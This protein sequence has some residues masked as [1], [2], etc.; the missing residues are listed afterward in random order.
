MGRILVADDS[1]LGRRVALKELISKDKGLQRR[2]AREVRITARL[3]HPGIVPVYEAGHWPD[4]EPFYAMKLVS[5]TSLEK[6]V[7]T[8]PELEERL[9][10]LPN[11]VHLAEAIAYAHANGVIHR[12]LKP[13]NVLVGEYGET[14]VVDWGLAKE[15]GDPDEV[16][17]VS[18]PPAQMGMTVHGAIVGTPAYMPPEQARGEAVGARAD[19]YSLGALIWHVLVGRPPYLGKV[20]EILTAVR[21]RPPPSLRDAA[22]DVPEELASIVEH[23]MERDPD[24]R[25][26]SARELAEELSRFQ[27]GQLV[28]RH[29]YSTWELVKRW[30]KRHRAAVMSSAALLVGAS[31]VGVIAMRQVVAE[32]DRA[33]AMTLA[34]LEEQGRR[35]LVDGHPLRAAVYLS[36]AYRGGRQGEALRLMLGEAMRAVDASIATWSAG[37]W[38]RHLGWVSKDELVA[39]ADDGT[40]TIWDVANNTRSAIAGDAVRPKSIAIADNGGLLGVLGDA[41]VRIVDLRARTATVVKL[42]TFLPRDVGVVP[43]GD[44]VAVRSDTAVR[45]FTADG[46]EREIPA[47]MPITFTR[48]SEYAGGAVRISDVRAEDADAVSSFQV[49]TTGNETGRPLGRRDQRDTYA[50]G[51]I[52]SAGKRFAAGTPDGVVRL[53]DVATGLPL[54]DLDGHT[55]SVRALAFEAQGK[56]LAS[57]GDDGIVRVWDLTAPWTTLA[58]PASTTTH[59]AAT[60]S[61]GVRAEAKLNVVE[62]TGRSLRGHEELVSWLD[63]SSDGTSIVAGARDGKVLRWDSNGRELGKWQLTSSITA[64]DHAAQGATFAVGARDGSVRI[65]RDGGLAVPLADHATAVHS[66]AWHPRRLELLSAADTAVRVW[67][68]SGSLLRYLSAGE[69]IGRAWWAADGKWIAA[70]GETS[71]Q[72]WDGEHGTLLAR[73]PHGLGPQPQPPQ[74]TA[75]HGAHGDGAGVARLG[76]TGLIPWPLPRETRPASKILSA[77]AERVP[78]RLADGELVPATNLVAVRTDDAGQREGVTYNFSGETLEASP[79][80]PAVPLALSTTAILNVFRAINAGDRPAARS[81]LAVLADTKDARNA[82]DIAWAWHFVGEPAAAFTMVTRAYAMWADAAT[83]PLVLADVLRFAAW[84]EIDHEA[85]KTALGATAVD[86]KTLLALAQTYDDL[87][88]FSLVTPTID[89]ITKTD[90]WIL[91]VRGQHLAARRAYMRGDLTIAVQDLEIAARAIPA[92]KLPAITLGEKCGDAPVPTELPADPEIAAATSIGN[93]AHALAAES[94]R[95]FRTVYD[96]RYALAARR[97]YSLLGNKFGVP[98]DRVSACDV[99]IDAIAVSSAG[100]TGQLDKPGLRNAFTRQR[101]ALMACYQREVDSDA[102]VEGNV[103]V[104]LDIATNGQVSAVDTYPTPDTPAMQSLATCVRTAMARPELPRQIS[105]SRML[106]NYPLTFARPAA[107]PKK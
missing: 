103:M 107:P 96:Y 87:G 55:R 102:K 17:P 98:V 82:Y 58:A 53:W 12:D 62:V 31:I 94:L 27:T 69:P 80:T 52:D 25:Y 72:I 66:L 44:A 7:E 71:L 22:P 4:G 84:A 40:V 56:R 19:V 13:A 15:V 105:T 61:N 70:D 24:L 16:S 88:R 10:L 77:V 68:V 42:P 43:G 100:K 29:R 99:E 8:K 6:V 37:A 46:K 38:I 47:A 33:R 26:P 63:I 11:L 30:V 95:T 101:A 92:T 20:D 41:A 36:Q 60:S 89:A 54:A 93:L 65:V 28:T 51:A 39:V 86:N 59:V 57:A 9:R 74:A 14:V 32:R 106:V 79:S 48:S 49:V 97:L 34:A 5:G 76:A 45:A 78:W 85:V 21:T 91:R 23:A 3:Q 35:E 73:F 2:F 67:S 18:M 90:D 104:R 83:K 81:E 75:I 1:R 64:G 50:V